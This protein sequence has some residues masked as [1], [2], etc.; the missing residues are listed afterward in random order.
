MLAGKKTIWRYT[1]TN[2]FTE[3]THTKQKIVELGNQI[4]T[5][6]GSPD[7]YNNN[8]NQQW[9][10][11]FCKENWFATIFLNFKTERIPF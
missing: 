11:Q 9:V 6:N 7:I 1:D 2:N 4:P 3:H 8:P 10:R 5:E